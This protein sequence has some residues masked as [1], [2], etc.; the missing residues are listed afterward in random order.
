MLMQL[1]WEKIAP[2]HT[3]LMMTKSEVASYKIHVYTSTL[4]VC[5][6]REGRGTGKLNTH[7]GYETG[8]LH[9]RHTYTCVFYF[10]IFLYYGSSK[11]ML[12]TL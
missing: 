5:M 7:P 1:S 12:V 11:E 3:C 4:H 6:C 9:I 2:T 8:N 10:K